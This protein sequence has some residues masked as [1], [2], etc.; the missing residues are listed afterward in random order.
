MALDLCII[1]TI[2]NIFVFV[3]LVND[4]VRYASHVNSPLGISMGAVLLAYNSTFDQIPGTTTTCSNNY[5]CSRDICL[6]NK[7]YFSFNSVRIIP[8]PGAIDNK[9][10]LTIFDSYKI[11]FNNNIILYIICISTT[12]LSFIS[13]IIARMYFPDNLFPVLFYISSFCSVTITLVLKLSNTCQTAYIIDG[14]AQYQL[15]YN[16]WS[17][18]IYVIISGCL[19]VKMIALIPPNNK[20]LEDKS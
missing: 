3:E 11:D 18:V 7:N 16:I 6:M 13:S 10:E 14:M 15:G 1:A 17:L 4:N 5:E 9:C 8:Y 2:F 19:F 12:T 20:E